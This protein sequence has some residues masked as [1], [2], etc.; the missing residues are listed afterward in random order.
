M[1]TSKCTDTKAPGIG[2]LHGRNNGRPSSKLPV[3]LLQTGFTPKSGRLFPTRTTIVASF[4]LAV[5]INELHLYYFHLHFMADLIEEVL[6][7]ITLFSNH[8]PQH[9]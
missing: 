6:P 8:L 5:M 1:I 9:D 3:N 2:G 7:F 4:P